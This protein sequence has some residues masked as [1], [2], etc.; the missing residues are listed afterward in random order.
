V[1]SGF[2]GFPI[3]FRKIIKLGILGPLTLKVEKLYSTLGKRFFECSGVDYPV[4]AIMK[5]H[6]S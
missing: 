2:D 4:D 3:C 6:G 5:F 1:L